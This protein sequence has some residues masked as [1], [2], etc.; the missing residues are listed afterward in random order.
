MGF[1]YTNNGKDS[2]GKYK[3]M[4]SQVIA[5]LK[6]PPD[7]ITMT[8]NCLV[9]GIYGPFAKKDG[10]LSLYTMLCYCPP[11][12][13]NPYLWLCSSVCTVWTFNANKIPSEKGYLGASK[14]SKELYCSF[15]F[16]FATQWKNNNSAANSSNM[17]YIL[18]VIVMLMHDCMQLKDISVS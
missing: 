6:D 3:A 8:G 1:P 17:Q 12:L 5:N 13:I 18:L 2:V 4:Y 10:K 15:R 7:C 16:W 11:S 9:Q 14:M